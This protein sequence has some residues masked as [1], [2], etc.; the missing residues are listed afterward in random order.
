ML[1]TASIEQLKAIDNWEYSSELEIKEQQNTK[2]QNQS[3]KPI[4]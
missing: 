2:K 4:S 3:I 1:E